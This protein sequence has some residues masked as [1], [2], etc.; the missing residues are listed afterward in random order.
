MMIMMRRELILK[1][2]VTIVIAVVLLSSAPV[3]A[4]ISDWASY[5]Q[6][7]ILSNSPNYDWWYGCS[8]TSAGMMMGYYDINGYAGGNYDNLVPGGTAELNSYGNPSAIANDVIASSG[9]IADFW[10]GYGNSGDDPLGSGRTIPSGF[11]SLADFM[12]TSQ[13]SVGNSDGSTNFWFDTTGDPLYD[14]ELLAAGPAFWNTDGMYGIGEYINYAGYGTA[15]LYS[16]ILPGVADVIWDSV[17]TPNTDGFTLADYQAEIDAG[18]PVM[19]HVEG[20]SMFGY[21]YDG[22]TIYVYDTW[23]D[24]DGGGPW[25]DGQ[26]PGT[27]TWGGYYQ[28]LLHYGVTALTVVPVPAAVLLGILGLGVVGIK[29]RKYA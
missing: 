15:T 2:I 29:L 16:Q 27:M 28:G 19:I 26:N 22:D 3:K 20:H 12:G 24:A 6:G 21:G 17:S 18:R 11:N 7:G 23:D 8:P 14:Y 9:H 10:T 25:E 4:D 5:Q 13:D 1:S